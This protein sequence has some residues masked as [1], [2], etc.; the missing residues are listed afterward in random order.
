MILFFNNKITNV[1]RPGSPHKKY[2]PNLRDDS[3]FDIARYTYASHAVLEPL[4]SRFVFYLSLE[5]AYADR[6]DE[7]EAWLRSIIPPEK[8][9]I[10]WHRCDNI[11][12]WRE[13][14]EEFETIED[15]FI[16]PVGNDDHVFIDSSLDVLAEGLKLAENDGDYLSV[17]AISHFP[18]SMRVAHKANAT[19]TACGNYAVYN[20]FN[21]DALR[22]IKRDFFRWH[23]VAVPED[24]TVFRTDH[25]GLEYPTN[26]MYCPTKEVFRHFD[27]YDHVNMDATV[28]APLEIPIGFF[29]RKIRIRYGFNDI[30]PTAVNINPLLPLKTQDAVNGVDYKFTLEDIPLFWKPFI[31]SIEVADGIDH[32]ALKQARDQ[33]YLDVLNARHESHHGTFS[34]DIPGPQHWMKNHLITGR[35]Q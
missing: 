7:M 30:D 23:L 1:P 18:E 17:L 19:Q 10:Y 33:H 27:G 14:N 15:P 8:L 16:Y 32:L 20:D 11:V 31:E 28:V 21:N 24:A 25:W 35:Q 34:P 12:Q 13:A 29:E 4:V 5:D 22:I 2:R 3:R 6:R 9:S 26:T